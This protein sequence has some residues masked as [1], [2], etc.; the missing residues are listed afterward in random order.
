MDVISELAGRKFQDFKNDA[1]IV[2]LPLDTT[3]FDTHEDALKTVLSHFNQV[4]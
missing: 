2:V 3:K 1:D 4:L